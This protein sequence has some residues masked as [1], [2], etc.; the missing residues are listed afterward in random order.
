MSELSATVY[1]FQL[2]LYYARAFVLRR[3]AVS[4]ASPALVKEHSGAPANVL[5]YR[6]LLGNVQALHYDRSPRLAT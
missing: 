1:S 5:E 4:I 2:S 6:A 3:R